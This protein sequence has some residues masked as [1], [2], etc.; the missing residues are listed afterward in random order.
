MAALLQQAGFIDPVV[1]PVIPEY[2]GMVAMR[3]P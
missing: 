1:K 3:K 2:T